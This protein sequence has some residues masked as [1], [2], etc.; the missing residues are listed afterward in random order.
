MAATDKD[1]SGLETPQNT[2][3][4][5]TVDT[6][7]GG[8][9]D[10][11][12][13]RFDIQVQSPLPEFSNE[14]CKAFTATDRNEEYQGL[15][16]LVGINSLPFR[17]R[18]TEAMQKGTVPHLIRCHATGPVTLSNSGE[19]H[20]A[21]ILQKPRGKKLSDIL[22]HSGS[23]PESFIIN[24]VVRPLAAM[25]LELEAYGIN[26]GC[27]NADTVYFEN[28]ITVDEC[29]ALPSGYLQDPSYEAP[30]RVLCLSG[31]KGAGETSGDYYAIGILALHL[32][33]GYL[34]HQELSSTDRVEKLFENGAYNSFIPEVEMSEN[35]QDLLRGTINENRGERWSSNQMKGWIGG[36]R[37]N[38]VAPSKPKD[39]IRPF[40]Y[41]NNLFYTRQQI[42]H[43]LC[44]DWKMATTQVSGFRLLRWLESNIK[45]T[46]VC[47][48]VDRVIPIG[49]DENPVRTLKN[50]ELSR[51]ISALDPQGPIRFRLVSLNVDGLG[52]ALAEAFRKGNGGHLQQLTSVIDNNLLTYSDSLLADINN[53]VSSTVLWRL[54]NLRPILKTK[55]LGFGFERILYQLNPSLCCQQ[56][57]L[58]PHYSYTV[59]EIL[60]TLNNLAAKHAKITPLVDRHIAAFLTNRLEVNR[61]IRIVELS[62]FPQLATNERLLMLKI[63]TMAQQKI[64]NKPLHGLTQW[65]VEMILP[66]LEQL[67]QTSKREKLIDKINLLAKK[68]IIEHIT[69]LVFNK[70]MFSYDQREH[71]RAEALF[72]FHRE[73]FNFL[74]DNGKLRLKSRI[75]GQQLAWF[76]SVTAL[77]IVVY[78]SSRPFL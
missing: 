24:Q 13:K 41:R 6:P 9:L 23:L 25:L 11:L 7:R 53:P 52:T 74:Q 31:A 16:A 61:E 47:G 43:N 50:D 40:E 28:D 63:L 12:G 18:A 26:H 76:M 68:G 2:A 27:I 14:L 70:D 1:T 44:K 10:V 64:K 8:D 22:S 49:D 5:H 19:T 75:M 34:P 20:R 59:E 29:S 17:D 54:Q 56:K 69:F 71:S 62:K 77:G 46:D 42:A 3:K 65:A 37:Y 48:Q 45:K 15:Y 55:E 38:I 58:L 66:A 57:M 33:L 60:T 78:I 67:H 36:K 32:H 21:F 39:S 73:M 35:L 51:L 72:R 30:E 4:R